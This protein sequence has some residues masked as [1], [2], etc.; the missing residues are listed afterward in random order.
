MT[1]L[2]MLIVEFSADALLGHAKQTTEEVDDRVNDCLEA[3]SLT[4]AMVNLGVNIGIGFIAAG[5][6]NLS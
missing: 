2:S 1:F 3:A 6:F 4:L 5:N